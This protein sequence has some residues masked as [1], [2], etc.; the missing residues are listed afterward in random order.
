MLVILMPYYS[1][2][3]KSAGHNCKK[4]EQPSKADL[5]NNI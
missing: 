4:F 1:D 2:L 3:Q 5:K